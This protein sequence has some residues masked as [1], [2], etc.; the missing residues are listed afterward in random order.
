MALA[1]EVGELLELFQMADPRKKAP[2]LPENAKQAVA[3]ENRRYPDL[4]GR[5]IRPAR[6]RHRPGRCRP[7]WH[8][9]PKSTRPTW[10]GAQL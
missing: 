1:G 5:A 8:S 2:N 3:H 7:K 10:P 4:P 6:H 9:M